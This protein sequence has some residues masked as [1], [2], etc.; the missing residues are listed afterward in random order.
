MEANWLSP[1]KPTEFEVHW[2]ETYEESRERLRLKKAEYYQA[3]REEIR[4]RVNARRK[5]ARNA[6]RNDKGN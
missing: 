6:R 5:L 1:L 3:N 2:R 4:A